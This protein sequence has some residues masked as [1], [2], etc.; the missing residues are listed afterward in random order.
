[1]KISKKILIIALVILFIFMFVPQNI[2]KALTP[3]SITGQVDDMDE[4][5]DSID[6]DFSEK[7]IDILR[8]VRNIPFSRS[9]DDNRN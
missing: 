1:M 4:I 2:T 7:V 6:T 5:R 8:L 9:N 3:G